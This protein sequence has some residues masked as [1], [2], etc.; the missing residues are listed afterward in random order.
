MPKKKA[1][2]MFIEPMLLLRREKLP[3]E[4]PP[5]NP[6][7]VIARYANGETKLDPL[8]EFTEACRQERAQLVSTYG[9]G[10]FNG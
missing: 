6:T 3:Y 4:Q 7:T 8:L 1:R 2:A 5:E 10:T 9:V